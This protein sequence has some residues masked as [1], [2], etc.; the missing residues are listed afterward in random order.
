M[1]FIK[2]CFFLLAL[3]IVTAN[4]CLSIIF[5]MVRGMDIANLTS[6]GCVALG[7][8]GLYVITPFL[9]SLSPSSL[10]YT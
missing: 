6:G 2:P 1:R 5:L 8:F 9:K 7:H 4:I 10:R 3:D